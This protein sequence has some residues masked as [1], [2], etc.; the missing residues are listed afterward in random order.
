MRYNQLKMEA[1][2]LALNARGDRDW[3]SNFIIKVADE[4]YNYIVVEEDK[5]ADMTNVTKL[6]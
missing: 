1:L 3:D 2:H 5:E 6:N 4:F